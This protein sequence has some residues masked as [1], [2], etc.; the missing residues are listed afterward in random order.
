[1]LLAQVIL[2]VG[3]EYVTGHADGFLLDDTAQGNDGDLRGA[4]A[5]IHHHIALGGFHVQAD[6]EGCGHGFVDQVHVTAAGMFRRV[7]HRTDLH[8]RGA[9][10]DAHYQFQVG[11]EEAAVTGIDLA[12]ESADHHFRGVEVGDNAVPQ[13]PHGL[14]ARIGLF[15]HQF[16][17]LAQGDT[18]PCLV[19]DGHDGGLVQGNLVILENDGIG[20]AQVYSQFLV[21]KSKCHIVGV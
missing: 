12:D 5:D 11:G 18:L 19:V 4:A 8:F 6:T 16:G 15:V 1:M 13:G 17:L 21:Q 3:R 9:G 7:T 2:D 14:D 20:G 10:G